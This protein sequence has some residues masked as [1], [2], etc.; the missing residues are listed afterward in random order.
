MTS[1]GQLPQYELRTAEYSETPSRHQTEIPELGLP[2]FW[3]LWDFVGHYLFSAS[4]F[5][6]EKFGRCCPR[7]QKLK[8][9][10]PCTRPTH[11]HGSNLWP[12][13]VFCSRFPEVSILYSWHHETLAHW[14]FY[15]GLSECDHK[16]LIRFGP[17]MEMC[18]SALNRAGHQE[19]TYQPIHLHI[20]A[21]LL[22][23]EPCRMVCHRKFWVVVF[24]HESPW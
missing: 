9:A 2:C 14:V 19:P 4:A 7:S 15:I 12:L 1:N 10:N 6:N 24:F 22:I 21:F 17:W 11:D 18:L 5:R 3:I 16:A 13:H 20:H 23:L 8:E